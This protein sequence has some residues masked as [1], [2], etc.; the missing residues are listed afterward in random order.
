MKNID[1]VKNK[2]ITVL[3][4]GTSGKG[5]SILANFL[6]ANVLLSNNKKINDLKL[7]NN[8][9]KTEFSHSKRCLNSDLVIISP[10]I[11][12]NKST[13]VK[14]IV[15]LNIPIISEIEFGSWFTKTPIIAITGSNGKSTVVKILTKIFKNKFKNTM[16]GGNIG[17][18]FCMN[19]FKELNGKYNSTIHILELSSFQL[20]K[21]KTFKPSLSCILNITNDHLDRHGNFNNYFNDKLNIIKN[22][23]KKSIVLYNK[24][25]NKLKKYFNNNINAIPFSTNT[26][27]DFKI[28]S[29]KIYCSKSNE[30]IIDQKET[31]LIGKHNLSNIIVSIK[32]AKLFKIGYKSVKKAL[33]E[34][35]PLEHRMEILKI[36]SNNTF[37]NDSKGTNLASTASAIDSFEKNITLILGGYHTRNINKSIIKNLI[38]K[39]SISMV[40]CYGQIGKKISDII[41]NI[42]ITY[43]RKLF[44]SAILFAIKNS[45]ENSIILL[46]P[47]F[48]SFDQFN[49]FE[50]RGKK[51][52]EIVSKYYA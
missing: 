31:N 52:K 28:N 27:N 33:L 6:G 48:K 25:D 21:I 18:S 26:S 10:G 37:I 36:N 24:D 40:I 34:F 2:N 41:K 35:E 50:E 29:G 16:L 12:P 45:N 42:K 5:A 43:Y 19:I 20:Q 22:I 46:S 14:E 47:G 30:L 23:D 11:N 13:I 8:N 4:A 9:I 7:L 17:I 49:N 51:F 3:G 1:Y 15:K 38:N 32:I 44:S 39:N